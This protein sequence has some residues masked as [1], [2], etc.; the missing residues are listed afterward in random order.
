MILGKMPIVSYECL[1]L[2]CGFVAALP[3]SSSTEEDG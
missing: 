1:H 3:F 2:K